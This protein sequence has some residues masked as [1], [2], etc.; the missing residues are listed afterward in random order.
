M[1]KKNYIISFLVLG[2]FFYTFNVYAAGI[3]I[4]E[5]NYDLEGSDSSREWVEI[6]N[7]TG[8][9]IDLT[10]YKFVESASS[11]NIIHHDGDANLPNNAYAVIADNPVTFLVDNPSFSKTHLYD[12]SFSLSNDGETLSIKDPEGNIVFEI[13]YDA[14]LG[15]SGTGKSLQINSLSSW[16]SANP[17]PGAVLT[18]S[19]NTNNQNTQ[20]QETLPTSTTGSSN[21]NTTKAVKV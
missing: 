17:T 15:A 2:L 10:K 6:Y 16:V 14:S 13:N 8:A 4:T 9:E 20:T 11:H 1:N 5:I 18:S 21:I 19:S 12:S 3:S 7:N